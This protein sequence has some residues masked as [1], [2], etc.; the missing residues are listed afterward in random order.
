MLYSHFRQQ[1]IVHK[2]ESVYL[3]KNLLIERQ[4][5]NQKKPLFVTYTLQHGENQ[6]GIHY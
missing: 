5:P 6:S 3:Q 2:F 4:L 1:L